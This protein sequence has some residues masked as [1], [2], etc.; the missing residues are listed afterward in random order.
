MK[1]LKSVVPAA[2]RTKRQGAIG[3][4]KH[5]QFM[6]TM[7]IIECLASLG[8]FPVEAKQPKARKNIDATKH[9]IRFRN[10]KLFKLKDGKVP[11]ILFVNS[12]DRTSALVFHI[13]IFRI[14]CENGLVVAD[15]T[16]DKISVRHMGTTFDT[17]VGIIKD[18][19]LK[20]PVVMETIN[21][22]EGIHLN[23]KETEKFAMEAFAVRF[24][25]YI[26]PKTQKADQKLIKANVDISSILE[27]IRKEDVG[28]NLWLTMNRVQEHLI[29][30]GFSVIGGQTTVNVR[31]AREIKDMN[32]AVRINKGIWSVA[33]TVLQKHL[34]N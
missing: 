1:D 15:R 28:D 23:A 20:I 13:G 19:T 34:L 6:T 30:G 3:A 16:F 9:L 18:L 24:P 33:D 26:N 4:S 2:F 27:P 25:E 21:K 7:D 10:P 8:W 32:R 31:P 12:H 5:Y 11:E 29:K 14:I 17:V 22:F